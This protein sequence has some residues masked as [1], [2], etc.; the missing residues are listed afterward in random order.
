MMDYQP[1]HIPDCDQ[2]AF[3]L[4]HDLF[5]HHPAEADRLIILYSRAKQ[6]PS[7]AKDAYVQAL[8]DYIIEMNPRIELARKAAEEEYSS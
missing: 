5:P 8:N 2:R 1:R 6:Q 7:A 4:F 3:D